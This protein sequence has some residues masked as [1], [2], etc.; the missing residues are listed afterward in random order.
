MLGSESNGNEKLLGGQLWTWDE[1]Q[2]FI[3]VILYD[4]DIF[5]FIYYK[6]ISE[7][8]IMF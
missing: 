8:K 7:M 3:I 1:L 6:N 5:C 2:W 4:D